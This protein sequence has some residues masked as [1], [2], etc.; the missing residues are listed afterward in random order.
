[1]VETLARTWTHSAIKSTST[2]RRSTFLAISFSTP[3][4]P[5]QTFASGKQRGGGLLTLHCYLRLAQD[6]YLRFVIAPSPDIQVKPR[7]PL[8][9]HDVQRSRPQLLHQLP[10]A[11]GHGHILTRQSRHHKESTAQ[12]NLATDAHGFRN[13]L[14]VGLSLL[15]R[16]HPA[17][18]QQQSCIRCLQPNLYPLA[19]SALHEPEQ[20]RV[21]VLRPGFALPAQLQVTAQHSIA[22]FNH[23][24]AA[25]GK[26]GV[27]E[28]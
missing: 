10:R 27:A 21:K 24:L 23:P 3:N 18:P 2:K 8:T 1:V 4:S 9:Y 17:Q 25:V 7:V 12:P 5:Q 15:P 20:V 11:L 26:H 16:G 19:S 22:E 28:D 14:Q 6:R 13:V